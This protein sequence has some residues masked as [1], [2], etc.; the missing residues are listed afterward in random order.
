MNRV[1]KRSRHYIKSSSLL[2]VVVALLLISIVLVLSMNIFTNIMQS[3]YSNRKIEASIKIKELSFSTK[4][5][6]L[7][8]NEEFNEEEYKIVKK[9]E[10]YK[11]NQ[12]LIHINWTAQSSGGEIL[13]ETNEIIVTPGKD[14]N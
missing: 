7:F 12:E 3:G 5:N 6:Q 2:E 13:L 4:K 14:E 11:Q 9:V 1:K 10:F 8:I